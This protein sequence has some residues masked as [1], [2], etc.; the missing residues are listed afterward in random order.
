VKWEIEWEIGE[1]EWE[2]RGKEGK[3]GRVSR[4]RLS[5]VC[6]AILRGVGGI[7]QLSFKLRELLLPILR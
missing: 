3:K 6:P 2:G 1:K 4:A 7:Y 5:R